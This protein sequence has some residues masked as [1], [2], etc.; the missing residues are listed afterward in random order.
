MIRQICWVWF[1]LLLTI[2][3][4]LFPSAQVLA[5]PT[6]YPE[7]IVAVG[8]L[9]GD[10]DAWIAIARAAGLINR[11]GRWAGGKTVLVQTGDIV[12][13]APDSSLIIRDL[14]RLERQASRAG[15]R[16]VVLVGNHE[17]MMV[18]GDVRYV[19]AGEYDAFADMDSPR[20]RD[21]AYAANRIAIETFFRS[22]DASLSP[23]AIR[24][25]WLKQTPLGKIEHQAAWQPQGELGRWIIAKPAVARLGD[26]L[27]VHGGLSASYAV[28]PV[29]EI[30]RRVAAALTAG[31]DSPASIINDPLGP[32]WYRGLAGMTAEAG[33]PATNGAPLPDVQQQLDY[34]LAATGAKRI[35]IGHTPLLSGVAVTH[36]G[37]LVRVD[38]GNSR[39][40]GGI[41]GFVEITGDRVTARHV[42]RPKERAK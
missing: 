30:N 38:S 19:H 26:S 14:M 18:T 23:S 6:P 40:Y 16:V 12:D 41:P 9:H 1:Q 13:R 34:L 5:K 7:R 33:P 32:L 4:A 28:L 17:A 37:R 27:F 15:G 31:D 3:L 42:A 8:D 25:L 24:E 2:P 36:G 11:K 21:N 20:Q 22:R 35:V 39:A 10:H 29:D